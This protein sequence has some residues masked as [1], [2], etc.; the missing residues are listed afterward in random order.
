VHW[1]SAGVAHTWGDSAPKADS[2]FGIF[3]PNPALASNACRWAFVL[4]IKVIL[5]QW[6]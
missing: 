3:P 4:Q 6:K 5:K 2:P 1:T